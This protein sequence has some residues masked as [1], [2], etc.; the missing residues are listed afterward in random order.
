VTAD[1]VEA[2]ARSDTPPQPGTRGRPAARRSGT[3][4]R[5]APRE[6]RRFWQLAAVV[7]VL[8][9]GL[10]IGAALFLGLFG[11]R[12]APAPQILRV[13]GQSGNAYGTIKQ[14]LEHA[15]PGDRIVLLDPEHREQLRLEGNRH[16]D[17]AIEPAAG[18]EV[19]W[20]MPTQGG[21]RELP[22]LDLVNVS[23]VQVRGIRF[24]GEK[25]A[26]KLVRLSRSCPGLGLEDITLE[27]FTR[28]GLSVA[29]CAGDANR[30][31]R[32][33]R[34]KAKEP[35]PGAEAAVVFSAAKGLQPP[36]ND[37]IVVEGCHFAGSYAQ[38]AVRFVQAPGLGV[39]F[40]D[41]TPEVKLP[42]AR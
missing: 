36:N 22:L 13:G 26:E 29:N 24:D 14:A 7:A 3:V 42:G 38:S 41:V 40:H 35:A 9:L 25:Q 39:R 2:A 16:R 32:L 15:K 20:K 31:V 21:K 23:G 1:T 19:S 6:A 28:I 30:P 4:V 8:V 18:V 12:S 17:I 37:F 5:P 11:G 33:V 10:L 34:V 27:R